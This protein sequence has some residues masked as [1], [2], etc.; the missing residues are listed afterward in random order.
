M[1]RIKELLTGMALG[2]AFI[3]GHSQG[4]LNFA[5]AGP[6]GLAKVSDTDY[7]TGLA[8][9]NFS[10]D[11]YWARGVISDSCG[12]QPLNAPAFFSS[13]PSLAGFFFG[14]LRSISAAPGS[15]ITAQVR[16]WP[17]AAGSSW[18]GYAI[19]ASVLFQVTLAAS[20]SAANMT[21]LNG[22]PFA[23]QSPVLDY[24]V[25]IRDAGVRDNQIVFRLVP[26]WGLITSTLVVSTTT[27]LT[28]PVWSL[29]K[30]SIV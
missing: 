25:W 28:N 18:C 30:P 13:D 10:A 20:P 22:H 9:T 7:V 2:M 14:G 4:M 1:T 15:T 23:L 5:N 16:V 29:C 26:S 3:S 8:G 11:L 6:W 19:G 27:S 12:L 17:T 21:E 24:Y